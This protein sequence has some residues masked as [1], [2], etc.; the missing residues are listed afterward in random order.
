MSGEKSQEEEGKLEYLLNLIRSP[1]ARRYGCVAVRVKSGET[2][3]SIRGWEGERESAGRPFLT[4]LGRAGPEQLAVW[5]R[6]VGELREEG[7]GG[8]GRGGGT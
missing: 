1:G 8:S 7:G 4:G 3:G 6:L 5:V 2:R